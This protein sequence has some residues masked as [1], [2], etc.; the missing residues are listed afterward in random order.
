MIGRRQAPALSTRHA[1][2]RDRRSTNMRHPAPDRRN[3]RP[4]EMKMRT[5]ESD[6]D[7]RFCCRVDR[8][9]G[10]RGKRGRHGWM[11]PETAA[12]ATRGSTGSPGR[13]APA[14]RHQRRR[15]GR[16]DR[17]AGSG[18]S[19]VA[20]TTGA[21]GTS[22][23][24]GTT[25]TAGTTGSAGAGGTSA[26]PRARP[27][28]PAPRVAAA[29]TGTAGAAGTTGAAGRGGTRRQQPARPGRPAPRVAAATSGT[30]GGTGGQP[31]LPAGRHGAVPAAERPGGSVPDPPLRITFSGTP[32][33][34]SS[35][36]IQVF[37]SG[38]TS[39][40]SVDV[41]AG[42]VQHDERR[43]DVQHP[44]ARLRRGKHGGRR[45][46]DEARLR[47]DLLRERRLGRDQ[48]A[49][50]APSRSPAP[51]PGASP[52]RAP[53]R[54]TCPRCRSR[55]DGSGSFCSVQGAVDLVPANNT[56]A[57]TDH[58]RRAAPITGSS[59]S[60]RRATSPCR[61][62][63]ATGRSSPAPTTTT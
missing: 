23:A 17:P 22:G 39:V 13:P 56:S 47:A 30:A 63:I 18:T 27:E 50:A 61:A 24:A 28:R 9:R 41:G 2:C 1:T 10:L 45:L 16:H 38:G 46:P 60:S 51:P 48:R 53:R 49:R 44:A 58:D 25:G 36:R 12:R 31:N 35:G 4:I 57:V 54:R 52:P 40:A 6:C 5:G 62:R 19:G 11:R 15:N 33:V 43:H 20:G 7:L 55:L 3:P 26:E 14:G 34:G 8:V 37:N 29:T 21:A 42:S 32:T 59:T